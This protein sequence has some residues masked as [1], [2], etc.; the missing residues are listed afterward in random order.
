MLDLHCTHEG[1]KP[2]F[3]PRKSTVLRSHSNVKSARFLDGCDEFTD[4][5]GLQIAS[6]NS[7]QAK[8]FAQYSWKFATLEMDSNLLQFYSAGAEIK[9]ECSLGR[10]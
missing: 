4:S 3:L 2:S 7:G 10:T 1:A 6:L 5:R 9:F 8:G